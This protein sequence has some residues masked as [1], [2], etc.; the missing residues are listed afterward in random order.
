MFTLTAIVEYVVIA[1]ACALLYGLCSF[2]VLGALQQ[3]NYAAST[4]RAWLR[5]KGNMT[6]SRFRLLA[7]LTVL[8]MLVLGLGFSFAGRIGAYL[9]LIPVPLFSA[10]YCAADRRALKVPLVNT[11]RAR[12]IYALHVF[13]L[14]VLAF[15]LVL[16]GNALSHYTD[17]AVVDHLRYLPLALLPL[18]L[19]ELIPL[20]A[21]LER[22]FSSSRNRRYVA[23][24]Q[25][26]LQ[27]SSCIKIG[28]TGSYGKTSVKNFL[29]A[30]LSV[31]YRVLA[32]PESF[33]TPLG[34]ARAV[35]GA[36]L[37]QTDVFIAEMGARRKGDIA[38]LCALVRPDHCILTGICDQ[39]LQ[40]FGSMEALI[41][42]KSEVFAGT[43]AGGFAVV[44]TDENTRGLAVPESLQKVEVGEHGECA[45][46][47]VKATA[48]G[49]EFKLA[50][51]IRQIEAHSKLLGAH[52]AQN[53]ALAAALA[54]KLG[55]TKEEIAAGIEKIDFVPHRLQPIAAN[56]VTVLDDAYNA[57]ARGAEAAIEV[58]RLFP[59]RKFA[60]TPGLVELGVLEE[61]ENAALGGRLAG[62][63]R[64]VLVGATLVL[65]VKNGYLAAGGEAEK[66]TVVPTLEKAQELLAAELREGDTVL[67][68]NDLPD[69]YG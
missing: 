28:I 53:I 31:R 30:I 33:N 14:A 32:T 11:A 49:I 43:R 17:P 40:S 39:H 23:A 35:E 21:W 15:A 19:P 65:A 42:A 58:L 68:L 55:L 12:R 9:A 13:V 52:N 56:G 7:F 4:Y 38:E 69:I 18:L 61:Q 26:K 8:S 54:Y 60:V 27:A 1:L 10:V 47:D 63:D 66:L 62:L 46:L 25:K 41:A 5:R 67:F 51:G 2:T 57:N 3:G 48:Q 37:S 20:A 24:A 6:R 44:G 34:I 59:G 22:P 64:V 50:L 36:D 16:G 29:A 45:A